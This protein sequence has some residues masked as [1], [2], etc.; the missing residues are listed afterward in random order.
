V[1]VGAT[2]TSGRHEDEDEAL[3]LVGKAAIEDDV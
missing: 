1:V 3:S 2:G